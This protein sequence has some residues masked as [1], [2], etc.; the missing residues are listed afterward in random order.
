MEFLEW[1]QIHEWCGERGIFLD[2]ERNEPVHSGFDVVTHGLFGQAVQQKGQEFEVA[3]W[4]IE[5]LADW[6]EC[7]LWITS[8]GVWPSS[9]DWPAYY[10]ARGE[11]SERRSID[12]APG[13]LFTTVDR[14]LLLQ[15]SELV[16]KNA[17]DA[18]ILPAVDGHAS[19]RRAVISH[20]E[21]VDVLSAH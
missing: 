19:N 12:T 16:L 20:D 1:N 21:C 6:D 18:H 14:K 10:R 9:E 15:F 8:W 7:L 11:Q 3:A 2:L 4:L 13:H 17:W 5:N